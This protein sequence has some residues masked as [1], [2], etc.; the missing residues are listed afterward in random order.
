MSNNIDDIK[1]LKQFIN[2]YKMCSKV[3]KLTKVHNEESKI[4]KLKTSGAGIRFGKTEKLLDYI[5][6]RES[7]YDFWSDNKYFW[8]IPME[9][10]P[11]EVYGFT[12]RGYDHHEYNLFRNADIPT[13]LFGMYDFENFKFGTDTIILTEGIKDALVLKQIYPYVLA[14]NTSGLT[15]NSYNFVKGL[16]KKFILVYDN[17]KA[18]RESTEKDMETLKADRCRVNTVNL[19]YKDPGKYIYS[20]IDLAILD[21]NIKQY[22]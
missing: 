11:F 21:S 1:H 22:L 12:L 15:Q 2:L 16:T 14:L 13:V 3:E 6:E 18:G 20:P 5:P 19:R 4:F 10:K 9:I 7:L 17:D 8:I